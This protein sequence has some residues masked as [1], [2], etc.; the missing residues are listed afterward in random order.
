[1]RTRVLSYTEVTCHLHTATSKITNPPKCVKCLFGKQTVKSAPGST[2]KVL[3]DRAG[4]LRS[5]NLLPGAEVSVD[6]HFINTV[7]GRLFE[8]YNNGSDV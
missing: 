4:I 6:Q 8:E 3:K 5:G 7:K 1:M 2:I